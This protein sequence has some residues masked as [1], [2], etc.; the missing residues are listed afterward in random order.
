MVSFLYW[1]WL[2]TEQTVKLLADHLDPVE[3]WFYASIECICVMLECLPTL[4]N[5]FGSEV[6]LYFIFNSW[7]LCSVLEPLCVCPFIPGVLVS[8]WYTCNSVFSQGFERSLQKDLKGLPAGIIFRISFLKFQLMSRPK[9]WHFKRKDHGSLF[10]YAWP[11]LLRL[12]G[13]LRKKPY[14][15]KPYLCAFI[16]S[17]VKCPSVSAYF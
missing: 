4:Y 12:R 11:M 2:L 17:K 5:L 8:P 1:Y 6:K 3:V 7:N 10:E 15:S 13:A 16:L 14:R 9:L